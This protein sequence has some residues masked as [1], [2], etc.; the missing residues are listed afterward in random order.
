MTVMLLQGFTFYLAMLNNIFSICGLAGVLNAH[1]ELVIAFFAFNAAQMVFSFH[2][3]V[4]MVADARKWRVTAHL[5]AALLAF[6]TIH[7]LL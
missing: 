1:R 4:D 2:F 7:G 3:F 6:T 5:P